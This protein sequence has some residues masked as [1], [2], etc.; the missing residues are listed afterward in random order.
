[1]SLRKKGH[2]CSETGSDELTSHED[3]HRERKISFRI[4]V[5]GTPAHYGEAKF[6]KY[7]KYVDSMRSLKLFRSSSDERVIKNNCSRFFAELSFERNFCSQ[8]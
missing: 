3:G 4:A 6:Q 7:Y 8:V 2:F 1:M 5:S